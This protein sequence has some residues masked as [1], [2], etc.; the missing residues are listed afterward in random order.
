MNYRKIFSRKAKGK[1]RKPKKKK[2][3]SKKN[4]IFAAWKK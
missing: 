3:I 2:S 4:T 1:N